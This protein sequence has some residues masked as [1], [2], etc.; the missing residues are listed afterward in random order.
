MQKGTKLTPE[1]IKECEEVR[2]LLA[3]E[4]ARTGMTQA[5]LAKMVGRSP[6]LITAIVNYRTRVTPDIGLKLARVFNVPLTQILPWTKKLREDSLER[7]F[8]AMIDDFQALNPENRE[9]ALR[10]IRNLLDS[11]AGS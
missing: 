10:M 2:R 6:K 9:I 11:Q 5:T 4:K 8:S 7:E 1:N 3:I